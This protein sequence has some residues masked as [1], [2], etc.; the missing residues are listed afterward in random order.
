[1]EWAKKHLY[2][3]WPLYLLVTFCTSAL[4]SALSFRSNGVA[5]GRGQ[6]RLASS[7]MSLKE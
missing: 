1:M 4:I 2:L 3:A 5:T 6:F 7:W